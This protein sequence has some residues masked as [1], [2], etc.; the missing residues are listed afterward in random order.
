MN[1]KE[2]KTLKPGDLLNGGKSLE[3]LMFVK[4]EKDRYFLLPI[5]ITG[6]N[7][8]FDGA[9][10]GFCDNHYEFLKRLR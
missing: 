5:A 4:F 6:R 10:I 3:L 1:R 9:L 2:F 7:Y 8:L